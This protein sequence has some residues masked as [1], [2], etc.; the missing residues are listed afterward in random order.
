MGMYQAYAGKV[1]DGRPALLEDITLPENTNLVIMVLDE[2]PLLKTDAQRKKDL[3]NVKKAQALNA[4][5]GIIPSD[6]VVDLDDL[7]RERIEKRG[8]VE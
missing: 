5:K 6:F 8:L 4:L 2:L 3:R 1:L 7:R